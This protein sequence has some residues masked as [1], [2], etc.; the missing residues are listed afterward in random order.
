MTFRRPQAL[1]VPSP[2]TTDT[3]NTT[4]GCTQ[5]VD[6]QGHEWS[7]G[8]WKHPAQPRNEKS[9]PLSIFFIGLTLACLALATGSAWLSGTGDPEMIRAMMS[10]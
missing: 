8:P 6:R 10:F 5:P 7:S 2:L 1:P 3:A 4:H 9:L